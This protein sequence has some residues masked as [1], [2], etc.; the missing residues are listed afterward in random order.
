MNKAELQAELTGYIAERFDR[1]FAPG[2]VHELRVLEADGRSN[3]T[4]IGF[5]DDYSKMAK[6]AARWSG[7]GLGVY[8][9]MNP[10]QPDLLARSY[11]QVNEWSKTGNGSGND[12]ATR[13]KWILIDADPKRGEYDTKGISSTDEEHERALAK[14]EE[15]KTFLVDVRGWAKPLKADSANGGH[16]PFRVDHE[17]SDKTTELHDKVLAV[18][19][20]RFDDD[21]VKIDQSV[22]N[23]GRIWKVYGTKACKGSHVEGFRPHRYAKVEL[24]DIPDFDQIVTIEQMQSLVDDLAPKMEDPPPADTKTRAKFNL[25]DWMAKNSIDAR[26]PK[27]HDGTGQKWILNVCPF[28]SD[29]VTGAAIF[30]N[31]NGKLGFKCHHDGCKGRGWQDLRTF[32]DGPKESRYQS[33]T[34]NT[35][36]YKAGF[37]DANSIGDLLGGDGINAYNA[38]LTTFAQDDHGNAECLIRGYPNK[39]VF[40]DSHGWLG[41]NGKYWDRKRAELLLEAD[42]V[43]VMQDRQSALRERGDDPRGPIMPFSRN[44]NGTKNLVKSRPGIAHDIE[45]FDKDHLMLNCQN[46]LIN[47]RD[48]QLHPHSPDQKMTQMIPVEYDPALVNDE[49]S[50]AWWHDWLSRT[51][52]GGVDDAVWLRRAVGYSITGL[53][54]EEVLFY[55]YGPTRSGKGTFTE[56]ILAMLGRPLSEEIGFDVFTRKSDGNSQNFDLAPLKPCRFIAASES[57]SYER[58]NEAKVKSLTGGNLINCAFKHKTPFSY[59]P[60]FKV[61]LSSNEPINATADDDAVWHRLRVIEFPHSQKGTEDRGMKHRFRTP[62]ALKAVLAWAVRGALEWQNDGLGEPPSMIAAKSA[63]RAALDTVQTFLDDIAEHPDKTYAGKDTGYQGDGEEIKPY[64]YQGEDETIKTYA[65]NWIAPRTGLYQSYVA[66]CKDNGVPP[67]AQRGLTTALTRKGYEL[68][69]GKEKFDILGQPDTN[70]KWERYVK[71]LRMAVDN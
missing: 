18:L 55:I 22:S 39:Y 44:V 30:R 13:R 63:Q 61:W 21:F 11:N 4:P 15:V 46:G 34:P 49:K 20:D 10:I 52:K 1:M 56:T 70:G 2:E 29:H 64:L 31:G 14:T 23:A 12:H 45:D 19:A 59:R 69:D 38:S 58:F 25:E 36:D 53:T 67:K 16:L 62:E 40:T 17:V 32:K 3:K 8:V 41:W 66:W 33:S 6:D 24:D 35:T 5:F 26:D 9:T 43:K 28:N 50:W 47:L 71:G 37:G 7:R 48:G 27:P 68:G 65:D 54:K 57:N 42:I 60:Q 51:A